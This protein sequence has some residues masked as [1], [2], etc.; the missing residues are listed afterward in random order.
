PGRF[1]ARAFEQPE[2]HKCRQIELAGDALAVPDIIRTLR[3]GG[4]RPTFALNLPGLVV[5]KLPADF[6]IMV[7]W[8]EDHGFEAD[9]DALRREDSRLL[10]L[11]DWVK[12]G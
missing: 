6:P 5:Q 3:N 1:A 12:H 11:A 10:T 7:Q 9:I 2:A 4:V 8:F